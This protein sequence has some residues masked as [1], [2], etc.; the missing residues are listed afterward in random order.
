VVFH[1]SV[2]YQVPAPRREAF[3]ELARGLPGH[4]IS[5]EGAD[6]LP[7][8][9]LP[10]PPG[11]ALHNVLALDGVPLAWTRGHGQAMTWF[12]PGVGAGEHRR[13]RLPG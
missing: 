7:H 11:E 9:A 6:V 10:E 2:L 5:I 1:T 4:W 13:T 12:G 3:A 8:D